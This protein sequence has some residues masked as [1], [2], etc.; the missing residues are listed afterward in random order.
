[1]SHDPDVDFIT[2]GS[3]K[4]ELSASSKDNYWIVEISKDGSVRMLKNMKEVS[5]F[6]TTPLTKKLVAAAKAVHEDAVTYLV[7]SWSQT[8]PKPWDD[9]AGRAIQWKMREKVRTF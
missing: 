4:I 1:M 2:T 5:E 8:P 3:G 9:E 7:K 6:P